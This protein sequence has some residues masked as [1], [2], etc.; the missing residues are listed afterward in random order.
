ML[1]SSVYLLFSF[2]VLCVVIHVSA[3][4]S[5]C[6]LK[7]TRWVCSDGRMGRGRGKETSERGGEKDEKQITEVEVTKRGM[8]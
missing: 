6:L 8:L 4:S 5:P 3:T 1:R 2:V 7:G